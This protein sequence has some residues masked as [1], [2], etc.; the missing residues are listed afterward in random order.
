[1]QVS[2]DPGDSVLPDFSRPCGTCYDNTDVKYCAADTILPEVGNLVSFYKITCRCWEKRDATQEEGCARTRVRRQISYNVILYCICASGNTNSLQLVIAGPGIGNVTN[3]VVLNIDDAGTSVVDRAAIVI[4]CDSVKRCRTA[5]NYVAGD[6]AN[7]NVP[8]A[9]VNSLPRLRRTPSDVQIGDCVSLNAGRRSCANGKCN[10]AEGTRRRH[11]GSAA[12]RC[13]AANTIVQ[14]RM[15]AAALNR[16][17]NQGG[18]ASRGLIEVARIN[19]PAIARARGCTNTPALVQLNT[20]QPETV[21][22]PFGAPAEP[23]E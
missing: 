4:S 6:S 2:T 9:D 18:S 10:C 7:I 8:G 22:V 1:M 16:D 3:S 21:L 23:L 5:P 20:L 15:S 19:C 11:G 17:G 12:V 14:D 13:R